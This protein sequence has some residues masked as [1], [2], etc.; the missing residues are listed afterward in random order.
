MRRAELLDAHSQHEQRFGGFAGGQSDL[1]LCIQGRRRGERWG[2]HLRLRA[3]MNDRPG[4]LRIVGDKAEDLSRRNPGRFTHG[5]LSAQLHGHVCNAAQHSERGPQAQDYRRRISAAVGQ[6]HAQE[7]RA[8]AR[9]RTP[10]ERSLQAIDGQVSGG[11]PVFDQLP[12]GVVKWKRLAAGHEVGLQHRSATIA[13]DLQ[14]AAVAHGDDVE[15]REGAIGGADVRQRN[16]LIAGGQHIVGLQR[17]GHVAAGARCKSR[18]DAEA[19]QHGQHHTAT[20][21]SLPPR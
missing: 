14:Q 4:K 1:S 16:P 20:T 2:R 8:R 17:E 11:N 15:A 9:R 7:R 21:R 10:G 19:R 3:R 13:G 18:Q 12:G 5:P 6:R